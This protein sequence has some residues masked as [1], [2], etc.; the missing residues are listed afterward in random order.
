MTRSAMASATSCPKQLAM[1]CSQLPIG[2]RIACPPRR[3]RVRRSCFHRPVSTGDAEHLAERSSAAFDNPFVVGKHAHRGGLQRRHRASHPR[4]AT[5]RRVLLRSADVAMY[6]R[7]ADPCRAT[8]V[9]RPA[10]TT[11]SLSRLALATQ[12]R[13]AL[14]GLT[15]SGAALPAQDRIA[16]G[17]PTGRRGAGA[18]AAPT[19]RHCCRRANSC[20]RVEMTDMIRRLTHWVI[21]PRLPRRSPHGCGGVCPL[22]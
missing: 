5:A 11:N 21:E 6:R 17:G 20:P 19:A 7:Q 2:S 22:R 8:P 4:M 9:R 13:P 16:S 15:S 10:R 18:L 14:E 12:S 3:R 1:R